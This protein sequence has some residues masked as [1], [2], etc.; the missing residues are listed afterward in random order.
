[1]KEHKDFRKFEKQRSFHNSF[2]DRDLKKFSQKIVSNIIELKDGDFFRG[3]V[4]IL[5]K[6]QP[7]PVIFVISDGYASVDA[8]TKES[9]FKEG[10]IVEIEGEAKERAG[11][12]Q[13]E[14]DRINKFLEIIIIILIT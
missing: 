9:D 5:R 13:V 2:Q 7:G 11:K 14:I 6:T 1:M 10:E 12:L 3:D 8:V 4:K